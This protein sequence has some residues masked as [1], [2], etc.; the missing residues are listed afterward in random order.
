M[1][2]SAGV[3]DP[4]VDNLLFHL[5]LGFPFLGGGDVDLGPE[6]LGRQ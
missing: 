1:Q 5:H 4:E 2:E 3:L 6:Q